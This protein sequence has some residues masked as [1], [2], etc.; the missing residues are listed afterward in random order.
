MVKQSETKQTAI[1]KEVAD[2]VSSGWSSQ[3]QSLHK[4]ISE[5]SLSK[6]ENYDYSFYLFWS[7]SEIP[8]SVDLIHVFIS[9]IVECDRGIRHDRGTMSHII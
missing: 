7:A 4:T 1:N 6:Y 8:G 3:Q 5:M 2:S 9:T